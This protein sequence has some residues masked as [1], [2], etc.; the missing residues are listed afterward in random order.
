M[1]ADNHKI[2]IRADIRPAGQHE[3]R[4][5]APQTNEVAVVI[6]DNEC[7]RRDII[8]LRRSDKWRHISE[9]HRSYDA[10]QYSLI[11]CEDTPGCTGK[12]FLINLIL[13][14]IRANKEIVLALASPEVATTLMDGGRKTHSGLK[15][16]LNVADYELRYV[17]S[18]NHPHVDKY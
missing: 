12:M 4:F 9:T 17:T 14:E 16:S 15:L 7:S 5:N 2:F 6:V 11:F 3:R 18:S 1:F 10:L 13:A 8:V